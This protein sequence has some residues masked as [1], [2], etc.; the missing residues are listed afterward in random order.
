[1]FHRIRSLSAILLVCLGVLSLGCDRTVQQIDSSKK[2]SETDSK[3]QPDDLTLDEAGPSAGNPSVANQPPQSSPSNDALP[4]NNAGKSATEPATPLVAGEKNTAENASESRVVEVEIKKSNDPQ[5]MA[6][7]IADLDRNMEILLSTNQQRDPDAFRKNATNLAKMKLAAAKHL[8]S[9]PQISVEQD[10]LAIKSQLVALSHLS[11]LK[12]VQAA[13]Q[14]EELARQLR[15]STDPELKQ[16]GQIVLFGFA[17]Q[18][19]QNGQLSDPQ[20]IVLAAQSLVSDP[21]FR[22]RLEMTSLLHSM[23]VLE[24]LG[25]REQIQQLQRISFDA[26][27]GSSDQ[28]L[29]YEAWNQLVASSPARVDFL[30]SL[31]PLG[32]STFD[33]VTALAAAKKLLAEFPNPVTLE[34]LATSIPN[35]EYAGQVEF[36][37]ELASLVETELVRMDD[38]VSKQSVTAVMTEYKHRTSWFGKPLEMLEL[39]DNNGKALSLA[40]YN[41]KVVLV[42]FWATWCL[43]CLKELPVIEKIY[44]DLHDKGFEV[45]SVNMDADQ[46]QLQQFIKD[47][48]TPW[49]IYRNPQGDTRPLTQHFGITMFPHVLVVG[50]DGKVAAMHV[51]GDALQQTIKDLL[52][53]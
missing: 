53:N 19:L 25:Y 41:G 21:R 10:K 30:N 35:I 20:Q 27:S 16:Q 23:S 6:S 34:M 44:A 39:V 47:R 36:S 15:E 50:R 38:G 40:D 29:R 37:R 45:L 3:S 46:S 1:M 18:N 42:D 4:M 9:L 11:G 22:S 13:K 14:L 12:D 26:F 48:S 32:T 5:V 28:P 43:P 17:V 7:Y 49:K 24:Q 51:R 31:D 33:R 8:A 2:P 52:A